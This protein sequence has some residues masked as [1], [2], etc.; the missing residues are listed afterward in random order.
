METVLTNGS[1]IGDT[2]AETLEADE[3]FDLKPRGLWLHTLQWFAGEN[4]LSCP[5]YTPPSTRLHWSFCHQYIQK[6]LKAE[7]FWIF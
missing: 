5:L 4:F 1:Y 3:A 6:V 7:S 2:E